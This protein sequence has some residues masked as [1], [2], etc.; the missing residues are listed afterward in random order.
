[1]CKNVQQE[2]GGEKAK[3]AKLCTSIP[4]EAEIILYTV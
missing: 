3:P 4:I 2:E 1:M